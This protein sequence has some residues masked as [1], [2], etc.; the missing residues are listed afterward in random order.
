MR[1]DQL[2][3]IIRASGSIINEDRVIVIGSQA[4]LAYADQSLPEAVLRSIEADVVPLN[5]PDGLKADLIDGAIG[6]G[7]LFQQTFGIYAQGVSE[8]TAKLALG[9]KD[10]LVPLTNANTGGVTGLCL[11]INDLAAAILLAGRP[12]DN[13][14]CRELISAGLTESQAVRGRIEQTRV[15]EVARDEALSIL[16]ECD[17][18]C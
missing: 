12:Q 3:H 4:I 16:N 8:S 11:E 9:W 2:E 6:E 17:S 13:E 14:S 15:A 1:R 5:D 10:R 18:P 7:S